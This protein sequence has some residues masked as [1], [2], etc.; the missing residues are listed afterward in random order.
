V[1]RLLKDSC[2]VRREICRDGTSFRRALAFR[3]GDAEAQGGMGCGEAADFIVNQA[4]GFCGGDGI[5]FADAF[6]AFGINNP[7][8]AGFLDRI[9]E[10]LQAS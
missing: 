9:S 2:P 4:R 8:R 1:Q 7:D 6:L 3:D 5:D 10:C